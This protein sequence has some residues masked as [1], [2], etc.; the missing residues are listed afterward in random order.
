ML[1]YPV[2]PPTAIHVKARIEFIDSDWSMVRETLCKLAG[3]ARASDEKRERIAEIFIMP[4]ENK[5]FLDI[6]DSCV[7]EGKHHSKNKKIYML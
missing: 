7:A 6:I 1:E 2:P 4:S 5:L 3:A